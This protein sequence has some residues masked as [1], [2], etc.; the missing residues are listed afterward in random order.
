MEAIITDV[1]WLAVVVGALVAFL[2]GWFWYSDK[3]FGKKWREGIGTG[4]VSERST[5]MPMITQAVGTF[6]LA[7]VIG[8]TEVTDSIYLA[9][10]IIL[11]AAV[12][13]KANGLFGMKTKYTI[14]VEVG[15]VIV[16]GAIMVL[17]HAV[18]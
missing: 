11:T 3:L 15:Y 13:V 4:A 8:V 2:V 5:A 16:M 12:I 17:T 1:N 14:M 10:L 18:L 6:L 7:W 9:I